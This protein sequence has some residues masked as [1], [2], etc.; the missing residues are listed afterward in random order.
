MYMA[1]YLT[2]LKAAG[3]PGPQIEAS[4][5]KLTFSKT[6]AT[7]RYAENVCFKKTRLNVPVT[8]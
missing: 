8:S 5:G 3:S 1:S 7:F 6:I 2:P 4:T